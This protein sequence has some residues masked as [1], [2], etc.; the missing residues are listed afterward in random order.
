VAAVGRL[1]R[2]L[3]AKVEKAIPVV[4]KL[5][6]GEAAA[7]ADLGIVNPE[8]VTV[9]AEGQRLDQVIRQLLEPAEVPRPTVGVEIEADAFGPALIEESRFAFGELGGLDGIVEI[10]PERQ[11]LRV[12]PVS[13]PGQAATFF[14]FS[15]AELSGSSAAIVATKSPLRSNRRTVLV[16]VICW[17]IAA[18]GTGSA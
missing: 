13:S 14:I 3:G 5:R 2:A 10:R 8:L 18:W 15:S 9:I 11:D 7:V 4:A 16:C 1:A 12:G 17:P 6:E